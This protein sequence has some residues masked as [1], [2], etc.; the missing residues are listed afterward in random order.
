[1]LS[2]SLSLSLSAN[3][4]C[5]R[6]TDTT[7][8]LSHIRG[9]SAVMNKSALFSAVWEPPVTFTT[10]DSPPPTLPHLSPLS[11][12]TASPYAGRM[13]FF[14]LFTSLLHF[15]WFPITILRFWPTLMNIKRLWLTVTVEAF[16]F[17]NEFVSSVCHAFYQLDCF[18]FLFLGNSKF[19]FRD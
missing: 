1:M 4:N 11:T 19:H 7:S 15:F 16:F 17:L 14:I 3:V 8:R 2:L 13:W 18:L 10:S 9:R 5:L 12:H 6:E